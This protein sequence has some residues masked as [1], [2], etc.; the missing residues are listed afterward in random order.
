MEIRSRLKTS[1]PRQDVQ[2]L[3]VWG[4]KP[5]LQCRLFKAKNQNK[6]KMTPMTTNSSSEN[7]QEPGPNTSRQETK[8][9]G[10]RPKGKPA[11]GNRKLNIYLS[12]QEFSLF[13]AF[14]STGWY[15]HNASAAGRYLLTTTLQEWQRKGSK[16]IG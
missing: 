16:K 9:K 1:G 4:K 7:A 6:K 13:M 10:G 12:D 11:Y 8:N 5:R 15:D 2:T 3:H 14:V